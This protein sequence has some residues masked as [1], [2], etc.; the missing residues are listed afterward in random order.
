[1]LL[2][3][4]FSFERIYFSFERIYFPFEKIYFSFEKNYFSFEKILRNTAA[5]KT[6]SI[7]P[8]NQQ[9]LL[10][11]RRAAAGKVDSRC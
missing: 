4:K 2:S 6:E 7:T 9:P 1:M 11:K 3:L 8:K 10:K 5:G